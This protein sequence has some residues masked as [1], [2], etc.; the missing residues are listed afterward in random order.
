MMRANPHVS[1]AVKAD[2][3]DAA[4]MLAVRDDALEGKWSSV[5]RIDGAASSAASAVRVLGG[6]AI[7]AVADDY[8]QAPATYRLPNVRDIHFVGDA[9]WLSVGQAALAI[10]LE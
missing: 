9:L 7:P 4:L 5:Y 3:Q 1:M 6:E 10:V 2:G 8:L